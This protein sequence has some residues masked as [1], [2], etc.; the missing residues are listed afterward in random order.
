MLHVH[1][2]MQGSLKQST[3]VC[4]DSFLWSQFLFIDVVRYK[5][6]PDG[7][8]HPLGNMNSLL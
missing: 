8:V 3:Q 6:C 7:D 1:V 5:I 4:S 2:S